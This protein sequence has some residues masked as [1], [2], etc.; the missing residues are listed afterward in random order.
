MG[1]YVE[2]SLNKNEVLVKK[3]ERTFFYLFTTWVKGILLCWLLL[4][5]L[6]KAII[7]TIR[8]YAF[9]LAVTNKRVVGRIGIINT[10]SLDAPLNKVQNINVTQ[11]AW[12]KLFNFGT[13]KFST[14][15]GDVAFIG[16]KSPDAFKG[17]IMAQ[18]EEYE[19]ERIKQ[20]A[21]EMA[22]AMAGVLNTTPGAEK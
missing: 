11:N 5:P 20:Q 8:Y 21:A 14:A 22:N 1:K 7:A 12:G 2:N 9:D 19:E 15:A 4:I 6:I 10:K 17:I 13:V 16:I 18:V 3:A